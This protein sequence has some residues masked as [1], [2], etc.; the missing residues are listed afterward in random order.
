MKFI[1]CLLFGHK[2]LFKNTLTVKDSLEQDLVD[3]HICMRC[4]L[5]FWDYPIKKG[6]HK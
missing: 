3:F 6:D 1:I 2:K 5:V 4:K